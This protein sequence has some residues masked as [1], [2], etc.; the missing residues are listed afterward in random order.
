MVYNVPNGKALWSNCHF[1]MLVPVGIP[2]TTERSQSLSFSNDVGDGA[3]C[4]CNSSTE[5][6][7]QRANR[8][9]EM[10]AIGRMRLPRKIW[11]HIAEF[12]S[13]SGRA[14][15]EYTRVNVSHP[16]NA[17]RWTSPAE[18]ADIRESWCAPMPFTQNA[19]T[20][21]TICELLLEI[22]GY[23]SHLKSVLLARQ[24]RPMDL[25][26]ELQW[27]KLKNWQ[28]WHNTHISSDS[29]DWCWL[30]LWNNIDRFPPTAY[31]HARTKHLCQRHVILDQRSP[32][33]GL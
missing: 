12:S 6:H 16:S 13:Y 2:R 9:Q 19:Y 1:I 22:C 11:E 17:S 24:S 23:A 29:G 14:P 30:W 4:H 8:N 20:I 31:T 28:L 10:S 26:T 32:N 33:W 5:W 7:G 3:S 15:S 27:E 21:Q 18:S 25:T